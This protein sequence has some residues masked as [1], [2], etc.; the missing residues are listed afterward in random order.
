MGERA[1]STPAG[2]ICSSRSL[3]LIFFF[4]C[5]GQ[6]ENPNFSIRQSCRWVLI[7]LCISVINHQTAA[8]QH[9]PFKTLKYAAINTLG[10]TQKHGQALGEE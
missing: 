2:E 9:S 6:D 10:I 8:A 1:K 5:G 4:K 7:L 3:N